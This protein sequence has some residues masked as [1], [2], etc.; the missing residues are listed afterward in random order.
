MYVNPG[1]LDKQ[2]RIILVNE[3]DE[4]NEN[5]FP[6]KTETLIRE[7]FAKVVNT[8]GTEIQKANSEFSEA[9]KR[10]LVRWTPVKIN[11]DMV[12]RYEGKDY[13]IV[14]PNRYNDGKEYAEIWTELSER[15]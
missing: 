13:S 7:C 3:G 2:I 4:T 9:K 10:F 5:G 12:V 6:I 15:V 1:E 8:S 11:T 14:Y